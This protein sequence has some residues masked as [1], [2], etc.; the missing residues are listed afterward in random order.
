MP[1]KPAFKFLRVP[2][3]E[4]FVGN[5]AYFA[6][7]RLTTTL[8]LRQLVYGAC[9]A[10]QD[11]QKIVIADKMSPAQISDLYIKTRD[12]AADRIV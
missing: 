12:K 8:K 9:R 1:S 10:R 6:H 5:Y 3:P 2:V 7:I 4:I 11:L